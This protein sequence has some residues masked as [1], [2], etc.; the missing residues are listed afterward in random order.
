M[1][2]VWASLWIHESNSLLHDSYDRFAVSL[3]ILLTSWPVAKTVAYIRYIASFLNFNSEGPE[4]YRK[5]PEYY[6]CLKHGNLNVICS[7]HDIVMLLLLLIEIFAIWQ[8]VTG[9]TYLT[10]CW[11]ESFISGKRENWLHLFTSQVCCDTDMSAIR[12]EFLMCVYFAYVMTN[13]FRITDAKFFNSW[14]APWKNRTFFPPVT[15]WCSVSDVLF[16]GGR[17]LSDFSF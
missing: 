5:S 14:R 4:K 13:L 3:V 11:R 9:R 8:V 7:Q 10:L 1:S 6:F 17:G 2:A 12:I 15:Q 16:T